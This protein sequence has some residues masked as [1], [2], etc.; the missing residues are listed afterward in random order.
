MTF[1]VDVTPT[2]TSE[3]DYTCRIICCW[4]ITYYD[5]YVD[6]KEEISENYIAEYVTIV[7][8]V[9]V[10]VFYNMN[11]ECLMLEQDLTVY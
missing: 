3:W 5:T 6:G 4:I 2:L 1:Y 8:N 7:D 11:K 9:L 10:T